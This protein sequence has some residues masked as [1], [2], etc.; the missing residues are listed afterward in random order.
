MMRE[1]CYCARS[2]IHPFPPGDQPSTYQPTLS[3]LRICLPDTNVALR[4]SPQAARIDPKPPNLYQLPS[5]DN[6]SDH[7]LSLSLAIRDARAKEQSGKMFLVLDTLSDVI[8]RHKALTTRRWLTD[9]VGKRKAEGFTIVATLNPLTSQR[10]K[11]KLWSIS[12][13]ASSRIY[14]EAAC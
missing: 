3:E 4:F 11:Y 12:S 5:I 10:R 2:S 13:M 8:L 14:R 1:T 9:F 6:L 7:T